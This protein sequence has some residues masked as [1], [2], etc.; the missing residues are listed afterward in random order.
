MAHPVKA[1]VGNAPAAPVQQNLVKRSVF[2]IRCHPTRFVHKIFI[3]KP[4]DL[5]MGRDIK[6]ASA[7]ILNI[8]IESIIALIGGEELGDNSFIPNP[9]LCAEVQIF[10]R[11]Q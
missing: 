7:Q 3:N 6:V 5:V 10:K 2:N 1:N 4:W 9:Q 8:P 11:N